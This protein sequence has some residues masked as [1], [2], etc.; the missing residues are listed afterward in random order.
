MPTRS[1][2]N[3]ICIPWARCGRIR[4]SCY[5]CRSRYGDRRTDRR[6][7]ETVVGSIAAAC[8]AHEVAKTMNPTTEEE[9]YWREYHAKQPYAEKGRPYEDYA[10]AYRTGYE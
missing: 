8:G 5:W 7:S 4:R 10:G 1:R 9:K 6:G 2:V 3:W